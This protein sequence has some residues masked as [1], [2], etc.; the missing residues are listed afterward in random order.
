MERKKIIDSVK[1]YDFLD[2]GVIISVSYNG[3][4]EVSAEEYNKY[5]KTHNCK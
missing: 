4:H 1:H 2:L 3:G 5:I